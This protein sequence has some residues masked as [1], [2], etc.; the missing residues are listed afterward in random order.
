VFFHIN[1]EK[2][3]N[4]VDMFLFLIT[5]SLWNWYMLYAD[6]TAIIFFFTAKELLT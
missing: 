6:G 5:V 4:I 1:G 3:A 2:K